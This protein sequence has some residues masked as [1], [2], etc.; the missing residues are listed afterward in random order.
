MHNVVKCGYPHPNHVDS[1]YIVVIVDVVQIG[2]PF[3]VALK[4]WTIGDGGSIV[5]ISD[6]LSGG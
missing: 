5:V 4:H 6:A 2:Y 3:Y 1:F